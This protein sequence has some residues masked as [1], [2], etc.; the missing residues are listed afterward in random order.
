VDTGAPG[1][2]LEFLPIGRRMSSLFLVSVVVMGVHK[3]E[4]WWTEEWVESPFF[5][6]L[7]S[8]GPELDRDPAH[9]FG[10]ALFLVFVTWL[11]AGLLMGW[12]LMRGGAAAWAALAVWGL[13]FVLE[14]HHLARSAAR[15]G[16][17]P[18]LYSAL[19]YLAVMALYQRELWSLVRRVPR[20]S[21]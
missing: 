21:G 11:F 4:C 8:L 7:V 2:H 13:T 18:G 19:V 6:L 1:E 10:E 17:Y 14:W 16:Y 15:G 9:A 12:L 5:Q 3:V 20:R